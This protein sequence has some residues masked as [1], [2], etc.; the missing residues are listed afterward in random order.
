MNNISAFVRIFPDNV[1][2]IIDIIG[3]VANPTVH[4][5]SAALT[6]EGIVAGVAV[7]QV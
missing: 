3:I 2:N 1:G 7:H 5:V 4:F 6:I